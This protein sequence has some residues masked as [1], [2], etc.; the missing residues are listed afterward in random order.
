MIIGVK[1]PSKFNPNDFGGREYSYNCC[2]PDVKVGD[3]VIAEARGKETEV[4]VSR[5][6]IP[7]SEIPA[8]IFK[9]LKTIT[10]RKEEEHE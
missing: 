8:N 2:I 4:K 9:M 7:A 5:V 10:K 6:D 1:F 3:I